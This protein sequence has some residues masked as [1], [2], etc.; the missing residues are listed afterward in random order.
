MSLVE[1]LLCVPLV[2]LIG[3]GVPGIPG[4]L[5]LFAGPIVILLN[6]QEPLAS[7]FIALYIGIQLGL[8]DSFRTGS[9]STDNC[10]F[11]ILL[12]EIYN[13]KFGDDKYEVK[14]DSIDDES[15]E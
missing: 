4:E 1:L 12:N 2:F 9:N 5:L 8:P 6:I 14:I 7:A 13:K 11:S 3:F 10:I 15:D